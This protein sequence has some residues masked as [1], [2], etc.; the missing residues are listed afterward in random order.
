[1]IT[2]S[3][4]NTSLQSACFSTYRLAHSPRATKGSERAD[5]TLERANGVSE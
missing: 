3:E 4:P 1:M 5:D 2:A